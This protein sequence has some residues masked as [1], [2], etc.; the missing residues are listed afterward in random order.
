MNIDYFRNILTLAAN[1]FKKEVEAM[2]QLGAVAPS[3]VANNLDKIH[4]LHELAVELE[5]LR[6]SL[7]DI[8]QALKEEKTRR[9][10]SMRWQKHWRVVACKACMGCS[11]I[12]QLLAE[13]FYELIRD[14]PTDDELDNELS[15]I[16]DKLEELEKVG[17]ETKA[18][19]MIY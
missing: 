11:N 1:R 17:A 15:L 14:P 19:R 10:I 13:A 3:I 7:L 16:A 18:H 9:E 12:D 4:D 2:L 8:Q 6:E 5:D